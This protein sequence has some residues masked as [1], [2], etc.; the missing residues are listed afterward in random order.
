VS[1]RHI[2]ALVTA[3]GVCGVDH[4]GLPPIE[5]ADA[6]GAALWEANLASVDYRYSETNE[7]E[8]YAF[9]P[10]RVPLVTLLKALSCYDYQSCERPDWRDNP[11]KRFT[12]RMMEGVALKLGMS[13][14]RA[15]RLPAYGAA[16]WGL[17]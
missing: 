7:R 17:Y 3:A 15:S 16:P 2:D 5:N 11:A 13:Q 10:N 14:E 4:D 6:L 9:S 8:P 1:K 12:D